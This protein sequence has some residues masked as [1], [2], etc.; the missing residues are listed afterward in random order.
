[1]ELHVQPTADIWHPAPARPRISKG[2]VHVWRAFLRRLG[3]TP[4]LREILAADERQR[5]DR[6]HLR[7]HRE[8][9]ITSRGL[10]R[11][12]LGRYLERD[13]RQLSLVHGPGGKPEVAGM[14]SPGAM[15]FNVSHS[16]GLA[17]YAFALDRHVGIDIERIRPAIAADTVAETFFS[18][19]E[20]KA[21][22]ALPA[23]LQPQAFFDAWTRKEAY[24]KAT[25]QG[26]THG[27]DGVRADGS[28]D[29]LGRWSVSMLHAA[30][31]YA[32]ALVVEGGEWELH[33]YDVD[34]I[35]DSGWPADAR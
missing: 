19:L 8:D 28:H 17:L 7:Q 13:P 33:R 31:G 10:L 5:A 25:G 6:Y 20:V 26:L 21:L 9:F 15:R 22:R 24:V 11:V 18:P 30:P 14:R 1:M 12:L 35:L 3:S 27:L 16:D 23:S 4:P 2:T 32:A 34:G 29:D